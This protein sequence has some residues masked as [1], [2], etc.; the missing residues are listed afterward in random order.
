MTYFL[1]LNHTINTCTAVH[2][3]FPHSYISKWWIIMSDC[4]Y[5]R[6]QLHNVFTQQK[7]MKDNH[8]PVTHFEN[9]II[10]LLNSREKSSWELVFA[11]L[12]QKLPPF[13]EPKTPITFQQKPNAEFNT[14]FQSHNW[15]LPFSFI[16]T[17]AFLPLCM[18]HALP[19]HP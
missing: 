2:I 8:F 3:S 7:W 13:M 19:S 17:Y 15:P 14:F 12:V 1:K 10:F 5:V 9:K 16:N 4:H 6:N 18:L 11:W